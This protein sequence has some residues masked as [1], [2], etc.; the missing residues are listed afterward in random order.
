MSR[1]YGAC[2][3]SSSL[4]GVTCR[5]GAWS[6]LAQITRS[7]DSVV[8]RLP[9]VR[10]RSKPGS[11]ELEWLPKLSASLPGCSRK[12]SRSSPTKHR[13]TTRCCFTRPG[14][15]STSLSRTKHS[16]F[17]SSVQ[18]RVGSPTATTPARD[19]PRKPCCS[20]RSRGGR[21]RSRSR[22]VGRAQVSTRCRRPRRRGRR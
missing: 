4:T 15:G 1:S 6:P 16:E 3:L 9:R 14:A 21:R 11:K 12:P 5:C 10:G 8:A 22:D 7:F 13:R 18:I 19:R 17:C 20:A 2:W